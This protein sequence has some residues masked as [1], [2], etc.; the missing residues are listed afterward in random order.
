MM[1]L[2]LGIVFVMVVFLPFGFEKTSEAQVGWGTPKPTFTNPAFTVKK[3][4]PV[5][6]SGGINGYTGTA[7]FGTLPAGAT[8]VSMENY[9]TAVLYSY[10][11]FGG[12]TWDAIIDPPAAGWAVTPTVN[13]VVGGITTPA[14]MPDHFVCWRRW[15]AEY[16]RQGGHIVMP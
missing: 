2:K 7:G 3:V 4:K 10:M 8:A 14:T 5:K 16:G 1:K 9:S 12:T 11:G 15:G 13:I 6:P